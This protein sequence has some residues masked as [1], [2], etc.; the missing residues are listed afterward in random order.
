MYNYET[1]F[2]ANSIPE[3]SNP[4]LSSSSSSSCNQ[5]HRSSLILKTEEGGCICLLC[6][7]NL[8]SNPNSPT[9]HV[10]YAFSQLIHAVSQPSFLSHLLSYHFHLILSPLVHSLSSF[11][12]EQICRQVI[13]LVS[14]LSDVG[15]FSVS[16]DF[17]ARIAD[18]LSSGEFCWSRRQ[19]YLL[20][21]LGVLLTR[22]TDTYACI[23]DKTVLVNNLVTGLQFPSEEMRG[24]IMFVLYKICILQYTSK[25]EEG[26]DVL[27]EYCPVILQLSLDAL[28]KI[29]RDDVRLNCLALLKV[30]GQRGFLARTFSSE[31]NMDTCEADDYSQT[32]NGEANGSSMSRLF[33]E[34]IKSPLL[35]PDIQVQT[36]TLDLIVNC[37]TCGDCSLKQ[38]QVLV[39]EN[40]A[41]YIF[42][43]LRLSDNKDQIVSS[44]VQVLNLLSTA[45]DTF[46]QRLSLGFS[47]L[48]SVLPGVVEVPFHP[49]QPQMLKLV[50]DGISTS[51]GVVS[52]KLVEAISSSLALML[53]R[54]TTGEMGMLPE[55]F[56]TICSILVALVKSPSASGASILMA[57]VSEASRHAILASL[58]IIDL[59]SCQLLHSL[60]L[61]KE[62][63]SFSQKISSTRSNS[64]EMQLKNSV[65]EICQNHILPWFTTEIN[66]LEEESVLGILE[67][68][69]II[70]SQAH[71]TQALQLTHALLSNSWFSLSFRCLGLY[72][73]EIMRLRVYLM[74]STIVDNLLGDDSGGP[75]QTVSSTL[76]TDPVDLL[77]L[78]GQKNNF[79]LS[80][81]Q[82]AILQI[83]YISSLY[84][85]MVADKKLI[86]TSLEQFMLAN[87]SH[88]LFGSADSNVIIYL[89]NLYALC[90]SF[91][92]INYQI[93]YSPDAEKIFF[94]LLEERDWDLSSCNIHPSS[95]RW[96]F[97]QEK[98]T[99][100]LSS[101]ILKLCR[102]SG[103]NGTLVDS[104]VLNFQDIAL[105]ASVG[106][107]LLPKVLV[108]LLKQCV[109][110]DMLLEDVMSLLHFISL[111][112]NAF[113]HASD[114]LCMHGVD[115]AIQNLCS[116]ML[117]SSSL[118]NDMI[119]SRF[120]FI[121]LCSVQ[122]QT[123]Y[124]DEAWLAVIMK[125]LDSFT[126]RMKTNG[127]K[128]EHLL[129]LGVLSLVL[130]H[131]TH[132]ALV[133]TAKFIL[134][135]SSLAP[136]M[137]ATVDG[138][139]VN[140]SAS[141]EQ[142]EETDTEQALVFILLFSH[143]YLRSLQVVLPGN[144]DWQNFFC[145]PEKTCTLPSI[146][147]LCQDVCRF[148]HFGSSLVKLVASYCL[149]ELLN[150]IT[151]QQNGV[152][153][154]M[155]YLR[156]MVAILEGLVFHH[157]LRIA[158][159]S[160]LCLSMIFSWE[161]PTS[162]VRNNSW[163]RTIVEE[164]AK[165][166]AAP[167][168]VSTSF[169]NHHRPAVYI[170]IA[171]LRSK[172]VPPWMNSVLNE[173]CVS[174][175]IEN[176]SPNNISVEVVLLFQQLLLSA[177][178]KSDQIAKIDHLLQ[179]CRRCICMENNEDECIEENGRK[180]VTMSSDMGEVCEF[181]LEIMSS[182]SHLD[183][184]TGG[185]HAKANRLM[186]ETDLFSKLVAGNREV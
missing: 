31:L 127:W 74:L 94:Q 1:N 173:A 69:H 151:D 5:G 126:L 140:G 18:V 180:V 116:N 134:L 154:S 37:L 170:T 13:D 30:L 166:L 178:L 12:D 156:S 100:S 54:Y 39:E 60:S 174:G 111:V 86:L 137:R 76:P 161:V 89:L 23:K 49:I 6:F 61:L 44:C 168:S 159:N 79:E 63:Y 15:G 164:L 29:Q 85:E 21:C 16:A 110:E 186:E 71:D 160:G 101:Q 87:S 97:Q 24:E 14:D 82:T 28:M 176:L 73:S 138:L 72:P 52:V 10:S 124:C 147:I 149:I 36:S 155:G 17:V 121:I 181:L 113:P 109:G 144:M 169:M 145:L 136:L 108:L 123:L 172:T 120:I 129:V 20:H 139:F 148:L 98:I 177:Y 150:G 50:L 19:F 42:E 26:A 43:I 105:L 11:D 162:L 102:N 81:C 185:H 53:K 115:N 91:T 68:L 92:K 104:S 51:P 3:S 65:I 171:L 183:I 167:C 132:G 135:N 38:I 96:L 58:S 78:L 75:I 95:L 66:G 55:T 84:D 175:I 103:S 131:S 62:A 119:V 67:T 2:S 146:G 165:S 106:D 114:Q 33:A 88:L 118:E 7:T 57:T 48:V 64:P 152:N 125:L 179:A 99:K 41:D 25:D 9:F 77:F 182:E 40:L 8:I 46:T 59:S 112:I 27:L 45:E 157:D 142:E 56:S 93:C 128:E 90:R 70:L 107:N 130:H 153:C 163:C 122:S 32:S 83:L 133:E 34:A 80:S 158:M 184:N 47:T 22:Q 141:I 117:C 4:P 143:F 35:S